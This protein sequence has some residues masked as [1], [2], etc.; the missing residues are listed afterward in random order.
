[1]TLLLSSIVYGGEVVDKDWIVEN[2]YFGQGGLRLEHKL[3]RAE[4]ATVVVRLL[5]LNSNS[6]SKYKSSFKDIE[7]FQKG[8]AVPNI[9]LVQENQLMA[10]V[11][12]EA[13]NPSGNVTYTE[14]VTVFM[15]VLGYEDGIDF[16]SYPNDYRNKALEIG[17]AEM[18][19][20]GNEEITRQ[21]V[22]DTMV[23]T[24]NSYLKSSEISLYNSLHSKPK[25][26][27][28]EKDVELKDLV[29]NTLISGV[30]K[31][32]LVGR[33]NFTGYKVI[34][35]T[36]GGAIYEQVTLGK[37]GVFSIDGFDISLLGQLSGYRYE[38]YDNE[39]L[40]IFEGNLK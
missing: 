39:G 27:K 26:E 19:I 31:G 18:Y 36:K 35:L 25:E 37:S 28:L 2:G 40:L 29:F 34:L 14:L 11:S 5:N 20:G 33:N 12:Q 15:R 21:V 8:W 9:T 17:L 1:M 38:I 24:L 23:K 16:S 22:L 32:E 3:N 6:K 4:L 7:G 30:F 13:F 10:G